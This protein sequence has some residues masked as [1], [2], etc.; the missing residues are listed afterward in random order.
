MLTI[1]FITSESQ[2]LLSILQLRKTA[3]KKLPVV[4]MPPKEQL[5]H[6]TK[7]WYQY[8]HIRVHTH[9]HSH[10]QRKYTVKRE[11]KKLKKKK[12]SKGAP[13]TEPPPTDSFSS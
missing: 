10:T 6:A 12:N 3:P 7:L 2:E 13:P 5:P 11:N 1:I 4:K 9:T 8:V